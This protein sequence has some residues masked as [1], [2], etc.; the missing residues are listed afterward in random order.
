MAIAH[1]RE[2]DVFKVS[3]KLS[4]SEEKLQEALSASSLATH[5]HQDIANLHAA[6]MTMQDDE[7]S[8]SRDLQMVNS[9]FLNVTETW[10]GRLTAVTS[11]LAAL[12]A[13]S[14]EAHAGTTE[15]VNEAEQRTR[16]LAERLEEL[17]DSSRRNARALERS[18]EDDAKRV[19]EQLDWNTKQIH[20]L[21]DQFGILTQTEAKINTQ[22]QDHI[23]RALE[24]ETHLPAVEEAVRSILKLG[25]DLSG[26]ERRLEEVTLQVFGT[27]DNMLKALNE[28][29][30]I[31]QELDALQ[32]HNSILKMKN[33]LS[34]VK[35]AVLELTM[36]LREGLD[37]Q[38]NFVTLEGNVGKED[39]R[40]YYLDD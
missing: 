38:D 5:L 34:I 8:A 27:E 3:N 11:D 28:I 26:V 4:A 7:N 24:C 22:L 12:K 18:E 10:Q 16:E 31:R 17:E 25:S 9:R 15:Q 21:E 30:E 37:S 20:R 6:I 35:E 2:E 14:R 29:L 33:E 36:T 39:S 19:Q 23:P 1:L 40:N 32:A 13:E